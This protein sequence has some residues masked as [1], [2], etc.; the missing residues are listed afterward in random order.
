MRKSLSSKIPASA[1]TE[2]D[3]LFSLQPLTSIHL[4]SDLSDEL[5]PNGSRIFVL[6]LALAAALILLVA[7]INFVNL[8]T[9]RAMDRAKEVGVRKAIGS[10]KKQLVS[11][12]VFESLFACFLA[13]VGAVIVVFFISDY[14]ENIAGIETSVF[15]WEGEGFHSWILFIAIMILGG[16]LTSV[17]PATIL[18]SINTIDVLKGKISG[19]PGKGYLRK[20]LISFQFFF[21][22]FLLS[23]TGAIYYQVNY[24]RNQGLGMS[25]EQVLVL[26]TPRSLIGSPKRIQHFENFRDKLLNYPEIVKVGSSGCIPGEEFLVHREGVRQMEKD[27]GKNLTYD[28]AYVDEGYLPA[29]EFKLMGGRNFANGPGE[30]TKVIP[31]ETAIRSLGFANSADAIG[32]TLLVGDKQYQ[33]IGVVGD[34]HYEGLQKSIRPLLLFYGHWYE[35][36]YFS[37]KLNPENISQTVATVQKHWEEI[38]PNDPFDYFFLD[39]YFDQ[40]YKNDRVFGK[41]FGMFSFLAIFVACLGLIGLVAFTTYRRTKEIGIRKV[42]GANTSNILGLLTSEFSKPILLACVIA[43]PVTHFIIYKWLDTFAYRFEF[44][45][46]MHLI[47]LLLINFLALLAISWQSLKAAKGNPVNA[48]REQ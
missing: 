15:S 34:A 25:A 23:C 10:T 47:P 41:V 39:S 44:A 38:Y 32:K 42:L 37:I 40:Q 8:A 19:T 28:V 13:A 3:Y 48:L 22:V 12:F 27:D 4:N 33:V 18:S 29:L 9:A 6:A 26:Y 14:I 11:Q 1:T 45:W 17:Y 24:M 31:N 46:W 35:F 30:G 21:A 43:I 7:W 20:S 5:R 16:L 36:G 2:A